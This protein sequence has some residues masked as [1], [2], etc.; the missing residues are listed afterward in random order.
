M[1][2]G[3]SQQDRL[4]VD[5][6][7]PLRID[8]QRPD[9]ERSRF[10]IERIA[11]VQQNDPARVQV[12][13]VGSPPMRPCDAHSPSDGHIV[14]GKRRHG[15]F[16]PGNDRALRID[17]LDAENCFRSRDRPVAHDRADRHYRQFLVDVRREHLQATRREVD[18]TGAVQ[19]H[20]AVDAG[21]GVPSA[22]L[23]RA[24]LD[25]EIV[26]RAEPEEVVDRHDEVCVA[27]GPTCD[28]VVVHEYERIAIDALELE[29]HRGTG[30]FGRHVERPA[31]L[32]GPTGEVRGRG[33]ARW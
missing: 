33:A 1:H 32:P 30:L 5:P 24:G 3:A 23:V 2:A 18:S 20:A 11:A 4:S 16:L 31:V 28:K 7:P 13:V 17:D 21:T 6:Q 10:L 14:A 8:R 12:R 9:S 29:E 22:V 25:L 15:P 26:R 19:P 27:T